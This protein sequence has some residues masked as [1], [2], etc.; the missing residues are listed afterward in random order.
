MTSG[1]LWGK[2]LRYKCFAAT[3]VQVLPTTKL[4]HFL[5][6]KV[7]AT[8]KCCDTFRQYC[9]LSSL[10]PRTMTSVLLGLRLCFNATVLSEGKET[11]SLVLFFE[12]WTR[13]RS[14]N[15]TAGWEHLMRLVDVIYSRK[16]QQ[17]IS[18]YLVHF[19]RATGWA[20]VNRSR[21]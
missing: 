21:L 1:S 2:V 9:K 14:N 16:F 7:T 20:S 15:T 4:L 18:R 6:W 17:C 5:P 8:S 19:V 10:I 13:T 12:G 3:N 11:V